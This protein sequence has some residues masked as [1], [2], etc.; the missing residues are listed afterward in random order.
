MFHHCVSHV[1]I[2][3]QGQVESQGEFDKANEDRQHKLYVLSDKVLQL[4]ITMEPFITPEGLDI[5]T[6]IAETAD[7]MCVTWSTLRGMLKCMVDLLLEYQK[8]S[9]ISA[10]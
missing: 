3:T 5:I 7:G 1:Q 9:C 2:P 6:P 10:E 4:L 8:V